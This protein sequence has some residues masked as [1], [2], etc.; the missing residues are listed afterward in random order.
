MADQSGETKVL[1]EGKRPIEFLADFSLAVVALIW[2]STFIVVK[3]SI[4]QTPVFSFLF[5]RFLLAFVLLL[6][7][8]LPKLKA[9]D[10][11]H[12]KDGS[13]LGTLLF[14]AYASQTFGLGTTT[15]TATAFIT[16]LYVVLVPILSALYLRKI[17]GTE[18]VI[19]VVL[20]TAG[21]ALVTLKGRLSLSFGELLIL[22]CALLYAVHIILTDKYSRRNDFRLLTMIQIGV[23]AML[24]LV[25]SALKDPRTVPQHFDRQLIVSLILT[26]VFATVV[27][28]G[29]QTG[30][31]KFTTPTK[32]AIIYTLEPVSAIFFGYWLGKEILSAQQYVGTFL[33][34]LAMFVLEIGTYLKMKREK[35][36]V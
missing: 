20:S 27:A 11:R 2:G 32:A 4:E 3:Q 34:L 8:S 16:S 28:I 23:V 30:M 33:I 26:G 10:R 19:A 31:Q 36:G 6:L 21:L 5:M 9:L 25:F 24:S 12:L 13:I 18:A 17:P 15:A 1:K 14:L 29:V 22:G 7:V 35:T